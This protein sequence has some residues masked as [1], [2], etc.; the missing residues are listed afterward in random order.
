MI[1]AATYFHRSSEF[2][3]AVTTLILT[4]K[5]VLHKAAGLSTTANCLH[6]EFEIPEYSG[7]TDVASKGTVNTENV[8][9]R[10]FLLCP[11]KSYRKLHNSST[12]HHQ[13]IRQSSKRL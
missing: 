13:T 1:S 12:V 9:P 4:H 5:N 11:Q 2:L 6:I 8:P 7:S 10:F 3:N